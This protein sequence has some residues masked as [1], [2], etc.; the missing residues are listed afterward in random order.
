MDNGLD[1]YESDKELEQAE[2]QGGL[3]DEGKPSM[4]SGLLAPSVES[5]DPASTTEPVAQAISSAGESMHNVRA[6]SHVKVTAHSC[7]FSN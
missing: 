2:E 7:S 1:T 5:S 3:E 6:W 4:P